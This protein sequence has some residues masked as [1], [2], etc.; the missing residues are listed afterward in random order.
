MCILLIR[1]DNLIII[2]IEELLQTQNKSLY[3]LAQETELS[4]P[5]IHRLASSKTS[6][7]AFDTLDRLCYVLNC[8]TQ[9]IIEYIPDK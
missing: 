5:T 8:N 2:K 7:I 3:W 1:G 9:D 6:S 4:Y